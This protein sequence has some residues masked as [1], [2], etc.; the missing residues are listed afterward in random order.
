MP[1]SKAQRDLEPAPKRISEIERYLLDLKGYLV[2]EDALSLGEVNTLNVIIDAQLLPPPTT[3]NRFG[4]A[5]LGSGFLGW[6]AAF[7]ALIDHSSIVD[8]LQFLLGPVF[9]L[10]EIYGI[11]EERFIGQPLPTELESVEGVT[12]ESHLTCCVV[13]NLTDTGPGIGGFCCVEGSHHLRLNPPAPIKDELHSSRHVV[14]PHAPAGSAIVRTSRLV[15]GN[16]VWCGPHQRRTL[17]FEY[18]TNVEADP[19]RRIAP[20][21]ESLTRRQS[22]ILAHEGA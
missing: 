1:P 9:T 16:S 19:D 4:T 17:I 18:T 7:I 6:D 15:H 8:K 5:P 22:A 2:I 13:W 21:S 3:Y 10:R 11:Y 20:P 14:V 12:N